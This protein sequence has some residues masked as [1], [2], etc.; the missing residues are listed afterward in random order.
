MSPAPDGL[1]PRPVLLAVCTLPPWPVRNGYALRVD[2]LLRHLAA[3]WSI[4]LLAPSGPAAP[5][6]GPVEHV[7]LALHGPGVTYPWRFDPGVLRTAVE[8]LVRDRRPHRA[9]AWP[10][11]E[12]AWP[13]LPPA[14]MDMID[15]N[16]LEF[17]HGALVGGPRERWRNLSQLPVATLSA[18]R[19]VRRFAATT[20][21]GERDAAWLSRIGGRGRVHVVPNGV[22]VPEAALVPAEA[23]QPMLGFIG[24]LD[25]APNIDAVLHAAAAIWPRIR[26]AVPGARFI[27]AGR[28][29]VAE[30][31]ALHGWDG[32]EVAAD[33]AEMVAVLGRCWVTLAPMRSGAGIKNKVLESWACARPVVMTPLATN[34]LV[35]PAGHQALVA[36]GPAALAEAVIALFRDAPM[37]H[38][39]GLAA[40]AQVL[41][42]GSWAAAADRLDQLL[43]DA[44]AGA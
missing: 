41:R 44:G 11:A 17:W 34:G 33:V 1:P 27:V 42:H 14:V 12:E 26:S 29:P 43:R 32:I 23:A 40:R 22:E 15:C 31:A 24:S 13:G 25:F 19:A 28:N 9:L 3:R 35:L 5:P 30:V 4:L 37:R 7:P 6:P 2:G 10:G 39:L 36:T 21:V 16:P 38:D 20:C 18:R 8:R